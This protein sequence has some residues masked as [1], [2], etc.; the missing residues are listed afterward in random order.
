MYM[1][2][3]FARIENHLGWN[4]CGWTLGHADN[5]VLHCDIILISSP[6]LRAGQWQLPC[7]CKVQPAQ[8]GSQGSRCAQRSVAG[9]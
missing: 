5:N 8:M 2:E 3:Q 4:R 1:Q 9:H 6:T 7:A